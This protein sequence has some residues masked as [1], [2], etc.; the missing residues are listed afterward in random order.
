MVLWEKD[1]LTQNEVGQKV[2]KDK[3][4]IARMATSLEQKGFIKRCACPFDR[5][6]QRL[7]LTEEGRKLGEKVIPTAEEFNNMVC[8]RKAA[9]L[10]NQ[11]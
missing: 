5:R 4:N 7:Y 3:T 2:D 6:S 10:A 8:V 1:G 11:F 9:S